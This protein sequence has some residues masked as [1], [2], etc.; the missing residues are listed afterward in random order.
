MLILECLRSNPH[1]K[2]FV[3][4]SEVLK[5][6]IAKNDAFPNFFKT[7]LDT[8]SL[9]PKLPNTVELAK[10]F[11]QGLGKKTAV[12][13]EIK[14][15]ERKKGGFLPEKCA[16]VGDSKNRINFNNI[17]AGIKK[18]NNIGGEETDGLS[19]GHCVGINDERVNNNVRAAS[20]CDKEIEEKVFV[21]KEILILT[22]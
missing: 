9:H 7:L 10:N 16:I 22:K 4:A 3:F 18:I 20:F 14:L 17:A 11:C 5:A 2:P 6:I 15:V 19:D 13:K 8:K 12:T 21:F 1:S